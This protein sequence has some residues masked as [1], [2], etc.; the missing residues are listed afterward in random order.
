MSEKEER[1][2]ASEAKQSLEM[3]FKQRFV[4][5]HPCLELTEIA[6]SLRSSQ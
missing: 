5:V 3:L 4:E 6:S 1:V 2:I